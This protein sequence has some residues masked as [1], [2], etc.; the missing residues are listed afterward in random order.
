MHYNI[1]LLINYQ[2]IGY[3]LSSIGRY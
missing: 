2:L 3:L 1:T